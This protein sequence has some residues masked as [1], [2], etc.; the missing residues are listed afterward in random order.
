MLRAFS[1]APGAIP[2]AS[3][4]FI[5]RFVLFQPVTRKGLCFY[6]LFLSLLNHLIPIG[7]ELLLVRDPLLVQFL[8]RRSPLTYLFVIHDSAFM[9]RGDAPFPE[10]PVLLHRPIVLERMVLC[11]P[12]R[13]RF[14]QGSEDPVNSGFVLLLVGDNFRISHGHD[15]SRV[16]L[17]YPRADNQRFWHVNG[18]HLP[19]PFPAFFI[20]RRHVYPTDTAWHGGHLGRYVGCRVHESG[21]NMPV[22]HGSVP[23]VGA[24]HRN[25]FHILPRQT[26]KGQDRLINEGRVWRTRVGRYGFT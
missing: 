22:F 13:P 26:K 5:P 23:L 4:L 1:G 11:F 19:N 17:R 10:A 8:A 9:H 14:K 7:P 2:P 21:I 16:L 6:L 25:R 20:T 3:L 18:H 12:R 24:G 15:F